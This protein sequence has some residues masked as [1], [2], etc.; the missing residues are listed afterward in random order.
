[1]LN[2]EV[3]IVWAE[4]LRYGNVWQE[5]AEVVYETQPTPQWSAGALLLA[6]IGSEGDQFRKLGC[7]PLV[8]LC[9][10]TESFPETVQWN[11]PAE[12]RAAIQRFRELRDSQVAPTRAVINL[13]LH[14]V[15]EGEL[16]GVPDEQLA[17]DLDAL[18]AQVAWAEGQGLTRV[19]LCIS[20]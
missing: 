4:A 6:G 16:D 11:S 12:L 15:R 9:A 1:M 18:E 3:T 13:Y 2:Y 5:T 14:A 17:E 7:G 10:D 8:D 20:V 19:C